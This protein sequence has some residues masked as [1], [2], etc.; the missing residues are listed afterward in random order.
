[1]D[2]RIITSWIKPMSEL[3]GLKAHRTLAP[4]SAR[5]ARRHMM[6]GKTYVDQGE[7]D[8]AQKI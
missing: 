6:R 3:S 5:Y 4:A 1:M 8:V 2:A 7:T